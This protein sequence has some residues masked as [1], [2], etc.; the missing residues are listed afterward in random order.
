MSLRPKASIYRGFPIRSGK[1][2]L[3]AVFALLAGLLLLAPLVCG[4]HHTAHDQMGI[5]HAI[6]ASVTTLAVGAALTV[7]L[8][9]LLSTISLGGLTLAVPP[10]LDPITKPPQ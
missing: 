2:S 6:C 5:S 7:P 1:V 4:T 9:V 10:L 3:V 8:M